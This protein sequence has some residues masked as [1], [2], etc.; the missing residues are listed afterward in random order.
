MIITSY[1]QKIIQIYPCLLKLCRGISRGTFI[2]LA[3]DIGLVANVADW[4]NVGLRPLLN[5]D[6]IKQI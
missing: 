3:A 6:E 4:H 2:L 1:M 5:G